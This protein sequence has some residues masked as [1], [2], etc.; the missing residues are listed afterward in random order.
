MVILIV[1]AVVFILNTKESVSEEEKN[2]PDAHERATIFQEDDD[3]FEEDLYTK[4]M[5]ISDE[6]FL[7]HF[8]GKLGEEICFSDDIHHKYQSLSPDKDDKGE[9]IYTKTRMVVNG[10]SF[11]EEC[12]RETLE[13]GWTF[14]LIDITVFNDYPEERIL[15]NRGM[16]A[17]W[18]FENQPYSSRKGGYQVY[19]LLADEGVVM[20]N[21]TEVD[22]EYIY[23]PF[24]EGYG[25][26]VKSGESITYKAVIKVPKDYINS[27]VVFFERVNRT[28]ASN[29]DFVVKLFPE[30]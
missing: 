18:D 14:C 5:Y 21:P 23:M 27:N 25:F 9:I 6:V 22:G 2:E 7:K 26:S 24:D 11:M 29:G 3:N 17:E 30:E 4:N 13:E 1:S 12:D 28:Y 19:K 16:I 8:T 10:V 15:Y 20:Y